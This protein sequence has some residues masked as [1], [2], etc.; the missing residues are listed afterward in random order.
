MA[1]IKTPQEIPSELLDGYRAALG[2]VRPDDG[3]RKR[4]PF[5]VPT[6]QTLT[7][8]P[9]IKQIAQRA[10]FIN[11]K[12]SFADVPW[13]TRQR[14][15]AAMPPWG[16]FLWYYNY[17]IMSDLAGNA[18]IDQG[19]A[20]VIK[21]IQFKQM[22]IGAGSSEGQVAIT[23]VDPAKSVVMLYGASIVYFET[24]YTISGVSIYPYVSSIAAELV[25]CKWSI[26]SLWGNNTQAADI[27]LTIIEYI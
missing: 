22:S 20:G 16:S 21:S 1:K 8:H 14:W 10:R 12:D 9:S 11:A 4:Y 6:I 24:E 17:F 13:E 7:G 25:K 2:E 27:G 18:N 3:V 15:Y 23:A 19:G 5:R 26:A